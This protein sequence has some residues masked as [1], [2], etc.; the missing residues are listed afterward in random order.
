[1]NLPIT[2]EDESNEQD[3]KHRPVATPEGCGFAC[4][5]IQRLLYIGIGALIATIGL[6]AGIYH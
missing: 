6:L 2:M 4:L 1:M 3:E 5:L